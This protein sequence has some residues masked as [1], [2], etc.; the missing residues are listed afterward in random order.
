MKLR[1]RL[2]ET[3]LLIRLHPKTAARNPRH[4]TDDFPHVSGSTGQSCVSKFRNPN[5]FEDMVST[6]HFLFSGE[7]LPL[8]DS[9]CSSSQASLCLTGLAVLRSQ[10]NTFYV[11][12]GFPVPLYSSQ[13]SLCPCRTRRSA[14]PKITFF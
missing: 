10:K 1:I 5:S 13:A 8:Q 3:P 9:P 12:V 2:C 6:V 7:S 11:T 14:K 4:L